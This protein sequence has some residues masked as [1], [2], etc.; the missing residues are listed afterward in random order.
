MPLLDKQ[1]KETIARSWDEASPNY[2]NYEGHGIRSAEEQIAW[3]RLASDSFPK[4][5]R[6]VLDVGCGTGELSLVFAEMGYQVTGID[7]SEKMLET[8]RAKAQ[9]RKL[10]IVYTTGDAENPQFSDESFDVVFNRHLLWTLPHPQEALNGWHRV[11]NEGGRAFIV[12]GV[13]DDGSMA[14]RIKR[15]ISAAGA[16]VFEGKR[17]HGGSY[18]EELKASLPNSRGTP[19]EKTTGYLTLAGFRNVASIDIGHIRDIQKKRMPAYARLNYDY[20][21]YLVYGEK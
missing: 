5:A 15:S 4:A 21:Y 3:K 16:R 14:T 8:A 1:I 10:D 19:L 18:S 17:H 20:L 11:L 2:D 13:W 12:D 7:I 9:A 6:T